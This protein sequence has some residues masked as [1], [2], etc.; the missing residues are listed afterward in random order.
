MKTLDFSCSGLLYAQGVESLGGNIWPEAESGP[1]VHVGEVDVRVAAGAEVIK[2]ETPVFPLIP[3]QGCLPAAHVPQRCLTCP[4]TPLGA[5]SSVAASC[6]CHVFVQSLI[7]LSLRGPLS[8][9]YHLW[10]L[11]VL[12]PGMVGKDFVSPFTDATGSVVMKKF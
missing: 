10:L 7:F 9:L 1:S 8:I 6:E 3:L 12:P 2:E 11:T 4:D 5:S